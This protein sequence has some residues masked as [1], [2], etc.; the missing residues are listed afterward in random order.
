MKDKCVI[1]RKS[2][3]RGST[4]EKIKKNTTCKLQSSFSNEALDFLKYTSI[5]SAFIQVKLRQNIKKRT[6]VLTCFDLIIETLDGN[7]GRKM[8]KQKKR[9]E[10]RVVN[11]YPNY[12]KTHLKLT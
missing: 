2:Q 1:V 5:N 3:H 8:T 6:R 7:T 12:P 9:A 11:N 4:W 10:K